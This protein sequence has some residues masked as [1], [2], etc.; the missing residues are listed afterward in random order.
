[1][2]ELNK[3][4]SKRFFLKY[5][6]TSYINPVMQVQFKKKFFR[7]SHRY[8]GT[9]QTEIGTYQ[10]YW[11]NI[12]ISL[13]FKQCSRYC[14]FF[15]KKLWYDESSLQKITQ[16]PKQVDIPMQLCKQVKK[17]KNIFGFFPIGTRY[18]LTLT[19]Y[20]ISLDEECCRPRFE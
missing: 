8:V 13:S 19:H 20:K 7:L 5:F 2:I 16:V 11:V 14:F 1:M 9:Y 15:N 12:Q 4:L 10:K 3:Y 18:Y 17:K 6:S